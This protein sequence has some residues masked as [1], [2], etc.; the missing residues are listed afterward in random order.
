MI[1][2]EMRLHM[3][4]LVLVEMMPIETVARKF[5]SNCR[6]MKQLASRCLHGCPVVQRNGG[7]EHEHITCAG[8]R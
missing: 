7:R 1:T 2:P 4:R 3:R 8:R 6:L 5:A